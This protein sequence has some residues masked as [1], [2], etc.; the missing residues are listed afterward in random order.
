MTVILNNAI[1][2]I[3]SGQWSSY[4]RCHVIWKKLTI[5]TNILSEFNK[6]KYKLMNCNCS[7]KSETIKNRAHNELNV[8]TRSAKIWIMLLMYYFWEIYGFASQLNLLCWIGNSIISMH[9]Y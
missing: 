1:I 7:M 8:Y 2:D 3:V 4:N 5:S 6:S 9:S